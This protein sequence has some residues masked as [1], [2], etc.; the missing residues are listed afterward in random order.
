[1]NEKEPCAAHKGLREIPMDVALDDLTGLDYCPAC[2]R[3]FERRNDG[4]I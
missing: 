2:D 4:N 3:F 1:M